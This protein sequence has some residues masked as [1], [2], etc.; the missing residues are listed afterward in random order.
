[1]D[2]NLH[3]VE[4]IRIKQGPITKNGH[5]WSHIYIK[6]RTRG[7]DSTGNYCELKTVTEII[8]HANS[9]IEVLLDEYGK[10]V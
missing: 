8:C 6:H 10:K 4:S 3:D 5:V 1:M 2:I 9:N 7:D